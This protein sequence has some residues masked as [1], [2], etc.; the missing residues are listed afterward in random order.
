MLEE[1][2]GHGYNAFGK[3]GAIVTVQRRSK[4]TPGRVSQ[5]RGVESVRKDGNMDGTKR[6]EWN[7]LVHPHVHLIR[8]PEKEARKR[9]MVALG[10]VRIPYC[11]FTDFQMLVT[12][13]HIE[14]LRREK[15]PFEVV[16]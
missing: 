5:A 10:E 13:E 8:I 16:S 12:N 6:P 3:T 11:G 14:V 15:I 2:L 1:V 4:K 7:T 9:A